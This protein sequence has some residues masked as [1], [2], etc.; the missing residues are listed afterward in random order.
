MYADR[1]TKLEEGTL[2]LRNP[3]E[4]LLYGVYLVMHFPVSVIFYLSCIQNDVLTDAYGF[5][6]FF[7][8]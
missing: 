1:Y 3:N 5:F 6:P 7:S 8:F 4:Q 2:L